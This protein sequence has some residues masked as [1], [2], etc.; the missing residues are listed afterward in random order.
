[1]PQHCGA[2]TKEHALGNQFSIPVDIPIG[3]YPPNCCKKTPRSKLRPKIHSNGPRAALVWTLHEARSTSWR[4]GEPFSVATKEKRKKNN[5]KKTDLQRSQH[6]P[7][8]SH[9]LFTYLFLCRSILIKPKT[10]TCFWCRWQ[11]LLPMFFD[12]IDAHGQF[13]F[14]TST[15]GFKKIQIFTFGRSYFMP[16]FTCTTT[17]T[18]TSFKN[19]RSVPSMP[20]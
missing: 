10:L 19:G 15:V 9:P 11:M 8:L 12:N 7:H 18:T 17:T 5:V 16:H 3:K 20:L 2:L 6:P 14:R 1:M 4:L 13:P